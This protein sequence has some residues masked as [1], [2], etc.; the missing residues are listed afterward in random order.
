MNINNI[1]ERSDADIFLKLIELGGQQGQLRVDFLAI[2]D[3]RVYLVGQP[4][5]LRLLSDEE[6]F[7]KYTCTYI[8]YSNFFIYYVNLILDS[9]ADC[10]PYF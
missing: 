1:E 2:L 4:H 8:F 7:A 5:I 3:H 9:A 10:L 6:I